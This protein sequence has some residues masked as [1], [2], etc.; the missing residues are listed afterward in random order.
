MTEIGR[1]GISSIWVANMLITC[2]IHVDHNMIAISG[3]LLYIMLCIIMPSV[4]IIIITETTLVLRWG[5]GTK[6]MGCCLCQNLLLAD[7]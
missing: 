3:V 7:I 1:N 6:L 2:K 4:K 5:L